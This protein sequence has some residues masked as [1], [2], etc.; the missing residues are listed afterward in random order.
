MKAC[1]LATGEDDLAQPSL[2]NR[3]ARLWR[4][5]VK[6][7]RPGCETSISAE[8][9][10]AAKITEARIFKPFRLDDATVPLLSSSSLS[11]NLSNGE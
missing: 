5:L 1:D 9:E 7:L 11:A 4:E 2:K 8:N 3:V 6:I 10:A